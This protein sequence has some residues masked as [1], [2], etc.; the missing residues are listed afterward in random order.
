MTTTYAQQPVADLVRE[1]VARARVLER[2]HIDYCCGGKLSL[3]EA[4][5]R[6]GEDV[7]QVA[8][9]LDE[10][11]VAAAEAAGPDWSVAPLSQLADHIVQ[12]HHT[13][14]R[15]ELPRLATLLD[16]VFQ[17]HRHNHP[18]LAELR[19]VFAALRTELDEHMLK[20]ER[21]LFPIAKQLE[22]ARA[23][24]RP[25]PTFHCGSVNNPISAMEDEHRQVG[26]ALR[27]MRWLTRGF[28]PPHDA[29]QTYRVLLAGL[30]ELEEDLHLHIHLENNILFPRAAELEAS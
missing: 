21:V 23:A 11:E 14:L 12:R 19:R 8:R 22:A 17:A 20:E 27:R 16:R 28:A 6:V 9:E 2:H 3:A 26:E 30:A 29:C 4:C 7:D 5:A 25:A 13:Y 24:S 10:T 1:Q 18:E 15:R